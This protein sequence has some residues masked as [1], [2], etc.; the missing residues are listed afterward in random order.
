MNGEI[1][2][3]KVMPKLV[4]AKLQQQVNQELPDIL[5]GFGKGRG[6]RDQI[7]NIL[8]NLIRITVNNFL[9][10]AVIGSQYSPT[11]KTKE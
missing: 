3:S 9:L 6:A 11:Y 7:V 1:G 8:W 4:Q 5:A 2:D 10:E